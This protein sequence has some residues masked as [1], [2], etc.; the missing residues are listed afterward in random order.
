MRY[1]TP[2]KKGAKNKTFVPP[3]WGTYLVHFTTKEMIDYISVSTYLQGITIDNS[4]L[5]WIENTSQETGEILHYQ[6]KYRGMFFRFY[7]SKKRVEIKGSLPKFKHSHNFQDL[8]YNDLNTAINELCKLL[9]TKPQDMYLHCFEFGVNVEVSQPPPNIFEGLMYF[10]QKEFSVMGGTENFEGKECTF[11]QFKIKCYDKGKQYKLPQNL[12]RFEIRVKK[13]E[14]IHKKNVPIHTL[15]DLLNLENW[16][17]LQNILLEVYER[18]IKRDNIDLH[19]VKKPKDR[20][21]IRDFRDPIISKNVSCN[22]F[23][24]WL[25]KYQKLQKCYTK[26]NCIYENVNS[27]IFNKVSNLMQITINGN[28]QNMTTN[29]TLSKGNRNTKYDLLHSVTNTSIIHCVMCGKS[30]EHRRKQARTCSAK[31]R[32]K[33]SRTKHKDSS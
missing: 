26:E 19:K 28:L 11:N 12:L 24:N 8:T 5:K 27:L 22:T 18:I 14:Y 2:V 10:R 17:R 4:P 30:I 33:L 23:A 3:F 32:T 25:K 7:P 29:V 15:A 20:E 1:K 9:G 31:C 6:C 16:V 21:F 13:M